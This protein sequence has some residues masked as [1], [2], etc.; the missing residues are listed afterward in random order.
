MAYRSY[1]L[2]LWEDERD[3]LLKLCNEEGICILFP[4]LFSKTRKHSLLWSFDINGIGLVGTV[5][6]AHMR[7]G[8]IPICHGVKEL[9]KFFETDEWKEHKAEYGKKK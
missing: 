8:G 2:V 7:A 3:E 1:G 5:I 9:K 6:M 4:Q